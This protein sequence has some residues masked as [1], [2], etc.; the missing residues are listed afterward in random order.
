MSLI[1]TGQ[2]F[3]SYGNV[4]GLAEAKTA[5]AADNDE[6]RMAKFYLIENASIEHVSFNGYY[7]NGD[8][9]V[10]ITEDAEDPVE[11][12]KFFNWTSSDEGNVLLNSGIEG[13]SYTVVN[14]K[15]IPIEKALKAYTDWDSVGLKEL[16]LGAWNGLLPG[17]AGMAPDGQA[18]DIF[19]YTA[20]TSDTWNLY[21]NKDWKYIAIPS[22]NLAGVGTIDP[23]SQA[24][25][26]EALSKIQTYLG[27]RI[28]QAILSPSEA[29]ALTEWNKT[30]GQMRTDGSGLISDAYE[31]NFMRRAEQLQKDPADMMDI[32]K[33]L[34]Y[35]F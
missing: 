3:S 19:N 22:Q 20:L 6:R 26:H 8:D 7:L 10:H 27:A 13:L 34:P 15:R 32:R 33:D 12:M 14:G 25:A 30:R 24:D 11:I 1:A 18:Y 29:E 9:F 35:L 28:A 5:L 21:D 23:D 2:V 4:D 17:L 31:K 16:G